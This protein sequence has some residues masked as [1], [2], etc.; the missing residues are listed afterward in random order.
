L[1]RRRRIQLHGCRL[2]ML[3][4]LALHCWHGCSSRCLAWAWGS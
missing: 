2:V 3:L 1:L 4:L